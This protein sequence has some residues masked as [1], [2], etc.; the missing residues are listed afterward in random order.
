MHLIKLNVLASSFSG[1]NISIFI[2]QHIGRT[3]IYKIYT[4]WKTNTKQKNLL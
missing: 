1:C 3:C 4:N 2:H